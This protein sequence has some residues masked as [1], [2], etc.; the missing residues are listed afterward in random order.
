MSEPFAKA[1]VFPFAAASACACALG[2][3]VA[4]LLPPATREPALYGAVAASFGALCAMAALAASADRGTN[5]VLL[6]F[7]IGF[8]CRAGLV[9]VGLIASSARGNAA[10]VYTC[11]F[12]AVYAATQLIEVLFV[13]RS[14]H[15]QGATR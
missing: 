13:H 8:L 3:G 14:S 9:A 4:L 15:P 5:G 7:S 11:A 10:L 2:I 12:F 6:G 1:K